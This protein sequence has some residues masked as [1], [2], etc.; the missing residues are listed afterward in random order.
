MRI[1]TIGVWGMA[2]LSALLLA[3][4][5][6]FEGVSEP[7]TSN[8][9]EIL[10]EDALLALQAGK[11]DDAIKYLEK[12]LQ[13]APLD[14]PLRPRVQV[15]LSNA[16]LQKAQINVLTLERLARDFDNRVAGVSQGKN[17][18]TR[19][20]DA[21]S[22]PP[23]HLVQQEITLDDLDGY[24]D[25]ET[26]EEILERVESIMAE[27]LATT[28]LPFDVQSRIAALQAQGLSNEEIAAALLNAAIASVGRSF[29]ELVTLGTTN[30]VRWY[31]VRRPDGKA[32]L[33]FCVADEAT[34]AAVRQ[35][36]ACSVDAVGF[37]AT[38][39]EARVAL[40]ENST[41]ARE[42]AEWVGK[43]Y[44]ALAENLGGECHE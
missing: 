39:L 35:A 23:D 29:I 2:L 21:C 38:L 32:Y 16:L 22:F 37:S 15:A 25:L 6:V 26:G 4:C 44:E 14:H 13:N 28:T 17:G 20:Q 34:V 9:P 18:A 33:G 24:V 36:L 1:R 3:R 31:G 11:V 19:T 41:I 5:N 7:G 30:Q 27:V 10:L 42:L 40:L 8:D 43:A 12:A